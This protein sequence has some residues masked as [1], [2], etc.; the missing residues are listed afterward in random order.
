MKKNQPTNLFKNPLH[1][2]NSNNQMVSRYLSPVSNQNEHKLIES[3]SQTNLFKQKSPK[4]QEISNRKTAKMETKHH[5]LGIQKPYSM[6][7]DSMNIHSLLFDDKNG[8]KMPANEKRNL[9]QECF[10][11]KSSNVKLLPFF[12]IN[13]RRNT[14]SKNKSASKTSLV[15]EIIFKQNTIFQNKKD[16]DPPKHNKKNSLISFIFGNNFK[17]QTQNKNVEHK[18]MPSSSRKEKCEIRTRL[19]YP[20]MAFHHP[21]EKKNKTT[22][23]GKDLHSL[24]SLMEIE[25]KR[26]LQKPD[27]QV[28]D[29]RENVEGINKK[30]TV[31][32]EIGSPK[33]AKDVGIDKRNVNEFYFGVKPSQRKNRKIGKS[34]NGEFNDGKNN[35]GT[36]QVQMSKRGGTS[37]QK[38]G[39]LV[40]NEFSDIKNI[41]MTNQPHI[42]DQLPSKAKTTEISINQVECKLKKISQ[43]DDENQKNHKLENQKLHPSIIEEFQ[44]CRINKAS[45]LKFDV[46][47][48][49]PKLKQLVK[50]MAKEIENEEFLKLKK[51]LVDFQI[52]NRRIPQTSTKF[53]ETVKMIGEG[54]FGKVYLGVQKLTNRLVAIK[55][56]EKATFKNDQAHKKVE[57]E[58]N[59]QKQ[60]FGHS[61]IIKL[62]ESF[63][64]EDYIYLVMEYASN[65]D[66]LKYTKKLS[67]YSESDAKYVF[68]QIALGLRYIHRLGFIHRDIKLDNILI[69]E[70]M[71]YKICD[72]GVGRKAKKD[73]WIF[74]QCGTPAYL[75]PEVVVDKGYIGYPA[76]IWSLG[77][78]LYYIL[79]G[80]MPFK[81]STIDKLNLVITSGKLNFP[82]N[83]SLSEEAKSLLRSM[84]M[85]DPI[86]RI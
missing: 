15:D 85:T 8:L 44:S 6:D 46:G 10:F 50:G 73:E 12:K 41:K 68:F 38:V 70:H 36:H 16:S 45:F 86:K 59:I 28:L 63:E 7:F 66:L 24:N 58:M 11:P 47:K 65:G 4:V 81:A 79:V 29:K 80:Q 25:K 74:E 32:S 53:Y 5:K 54:S 26:Y 2:S 31:F 60:L 40:I 19:E 9:K 43:I 78:L 33:S 14:K 64:N 21:L 1:F 17:N 20:R 37:D 13:Q 30:S 51:F 62:L 39:K 77:V 49:L 3:N 27:H 76:D 23:K 48:I 72:F 57:T 22:L 82:D 55:R 83:D 18:K 56:L 52:N 34:L 75:S 42:N 35:K 69:D 61:G 67:R 84:L 71:H